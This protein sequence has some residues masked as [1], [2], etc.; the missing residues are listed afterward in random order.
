MERRSQPVVEDRIARIEAVGTAILRYGVVFLLMAIGALKFAEF[1]AKAIQPLVA[2]SPFMGWLYSILTV[3]GVSNLIGCT[4]I[5]TA[6]LI[7]S[8]RFSPLASAIGS[9]LGVV[10]FSTTLSF[11]FTTPGGLSPQGPAFGFLVKDVVLLG[12]S[13]YTAG[14]ALRA[15]RARRAATAPRIGDLATP[16]HHAA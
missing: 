9:A 3:Q 8:R 14:E 2:N 4:E 16:A 1:E 15:A 5:A 7:A 13:V 11:L 6:I 10:I 12:A